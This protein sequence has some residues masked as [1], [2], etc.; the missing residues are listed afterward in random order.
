MKK[1][2]AIP[3]VVVALFV[4]TGVVCGN[5]PVTNENYDVRAPRQGLSSPL[6]S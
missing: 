5:N 2:T 3:L 4:A 6:D 1:R